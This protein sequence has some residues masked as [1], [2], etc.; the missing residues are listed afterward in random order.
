MGCVVRKIA[1]G[2]PFDRHAIVIRLR[3]SEQKAKKVRQ[4]KKRFCL[5]LG[6]TKAVSR[7]L[8]FDYQDKRERRCFKREKSYVRVAREIRVK[9]KCKECLR[10]LV[11]F[12]FADSLSLNDAHTAM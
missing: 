9:V 6:L 5:K 7:R 12:S 8:C 10:H 2:E 4:T 1:R 11:F 3:E